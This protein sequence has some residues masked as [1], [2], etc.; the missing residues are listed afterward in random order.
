MS[1]PSIQIREGRLEDV[2]TIVE[3]NQRMALE[4]ENKEL[5]MDTVM[6]GVKQGLLQP[7]KCLFFV[8]EVQGVVVGQAMVTYEWSDWD[9]RDLW[10]IQSVY[11]H[12]DYRQQGVFT[13][14]FR[15]IESLARKEDK[16]RALRLYV[17]DD[18]TVGQAVY[19]KLSM[20]YSGYHVY[21]REF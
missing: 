1:N 17:K 20:S 14:L 9:N 18:N 13:K 6:E 19:K 2:P 15:H 21:E 8:A 10:W 12:S 11:V 7:E 5:D 16:V 4:T 3:Y